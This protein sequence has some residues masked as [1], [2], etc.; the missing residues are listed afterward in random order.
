MSTCGGEG[1]GAARGAGGGGERGG[2]GRV[3]GGG[4]EGGR[5]SRPRGPASSAASGKPGAARTSTLAGKE[6]G[7]IRLERLRGEQAFW[8]E[9]SRRVP[10]AGGGAHGGV[11]ERRG[12]RTVRAGLPEDVEGCVCRPSGRERSRI[13]S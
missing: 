8:R 3:G 13:A 2:G 10:E 12:P 7:G 9:R 4:G 6:N 5:R 1:R 11:G